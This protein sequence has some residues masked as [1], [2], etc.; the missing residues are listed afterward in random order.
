LAQAAPRFAADA[1]AG[2]AVIA[3]GF[4]LAASRWRLRYRVG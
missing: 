4:A 1:A 2:A 3:G